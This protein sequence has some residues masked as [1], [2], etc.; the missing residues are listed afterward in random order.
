MLTISGFLRKLTL[1]KINNTA[2]TFR[3]EALSKDL[4]LG[5]YEIYLLN[6][7]LKIP[8]NVPSLSLTDEK[9]VR[10]GTVYNLVLMRKRRGILLSCYGNVYNV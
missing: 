4:T 6:S 10:I 3:T 5:V 9:S 7:E 2:L 1:L 8:S